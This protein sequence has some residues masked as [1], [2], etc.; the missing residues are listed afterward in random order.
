MLDSPDLLLPACFSGATKGPLVVSDKRPRRQPGR[1]YLEALVIL[2]VV[3]ST[4][5]RL[6]VLLMMMAGCLS[7]CG[8]TVVDFAAVQDAQTAAQ[9]KTALINDPGIGS[10][11]IEVSVVQGVAH[12]SGRVATQ[13]N[14]DRAGTLARSVP[15]V[16]DVK[17]NL[18]VVGDQVS[19]IP[20]PAEPPSPTPGALLEARDDPRLLAVGASL[21][22]SGPRIGALSTRV[23]IGPLLRLGSGRGFGPALALNW[24]QTTLANPSPGA[25][26]VTSR[27]NV[28]PIM[29][30]ISYTLASDRVS[31][32]P[33]IV[34]G[35]AFNSLTAPTT[36]DVDRIAVEV[37]NSLIWR[38]GMSVWF[39]VNRRAAINVSAGY[40]I[41]R[42]RV[43]FLEDGHLVRHD[44]RGDTTIVQAGVA[45][46]LF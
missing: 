40:M 41:T 18:Q 14:A 34:G 29:G 22:W 42:L 5:G 13:A 3:D 39:D 7:A 17:L 30:G 10:T 2:H 37:A 8:R 19:P 9:I 36:G 11:T 16:R 26:P 4:L 21:G 28:R 38:P 43:T 1:L 20:V 25:V 45:Y 12:L 31:I 35:L 46:K 23:S 15:G 6:V 32:S 24:F 27:I 44:L 33:S